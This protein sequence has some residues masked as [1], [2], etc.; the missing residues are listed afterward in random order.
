[1]ETLNFIERI[2]VSYLK[3]Y[4][5]PEIPQLTQLAE[6]KILLT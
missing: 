4:L 6:F 2:V 3:I 5:G 1:M